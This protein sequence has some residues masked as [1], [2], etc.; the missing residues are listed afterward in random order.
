MFDIDRWREIFEA[1]SKNKLRTLLT[2]FTISFAILLF[3]LLFGIGNGLQNTFKKQ[4]ADDANNAI[5]IHADKT[6]KAF[7]GYQS[8]RQIIFKNDD[9]TFLAEKFGDDI[10]YM[11]GRIYNFLK[12]TN[13]AESSMYDVRAVHPDHQFL[14]NTIIDNGRYLNKLDLDRRSKVVVIGRLVEQDL[15]KEHSA[16]NK[17]V[18]IDGINYKVVG[19]FSDEGGD[20]EERMIYMPITTAQ[21]VF[22]RN[23]EID[24]INITFNPN[25]STD[26][27]II[28]GKNVQQ[29]LRKKHDV[30]PKDSNGIRTQN[31]AE[32][33]QQVGQMMFGINLVILFIGIG[34]LIAGIVGIANIMVY[35]VKERTREL[36]IR[37]ALGA[38]PANIVAMIIQETIFITALAGYSGL[39]VGVGLLA[40][41]SPHVEDYFITNPSVSKGVVIGATIILVLSGLLAGYIPAKRAAAIKPIEAINSK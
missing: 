36:G 37:K 23:D 22:G 8:G 7:K 5:F 28:F 1:I 32:A 17:Y 29:E 40:W 19:V 35:V 15:F 2:G 26:N 31:M 3:T 9:I 25:M 11:S 41:L 16:L 24:Q 34:T 13:Q 4:F 12:V 20:R 18:T 21:G 14:E 6:T 38:S 30:D 39:L 10:Q 27:A 33:N